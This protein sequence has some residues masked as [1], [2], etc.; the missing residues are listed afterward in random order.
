MKRYILTILGI[1]VLTALIA[2]A[3]SC[4]SRMGSR[5]TGKALELTLPTDFETAVG[6]N[7]HKGEKDL[8]YINTD[9]VL[10]VKTYSDFGVLEG[11]IIFK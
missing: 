7:A 10:K 8:L 2:T 6:W 5:L 1:V 4:Q 9:G 11:S 3:V